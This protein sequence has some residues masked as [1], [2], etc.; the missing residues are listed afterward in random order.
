M[1]S[2]ALHIGLCMLHNSTLPLCLHLHMCHLRLF[3]CLSVSPSR[4]FPLILIDG[5]WTGAK[6]NCTHSTV[7]YKTVDMFPTCVVFDEYLH[8]E[9]SSPNE[10]GCVGKGC[11]SAFEQDINHAIILFFD[12]DID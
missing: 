6:S 11:F 12:G 9:K 8:I 2:D 7:T 3:V 5:Q 1:Y 10:T 4:L